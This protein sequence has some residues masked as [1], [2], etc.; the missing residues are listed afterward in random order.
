MD[1][2]KGPVVGKRLPSQSS[3]KVDWF[4]HLPFA[5]VTV[6]HK[7]GFKDHRVAVTSDRKSQSPTHPQE[8]QLTWEMLGVVFGVD[9]S[10]VEVRSHLFLPR[11][12][13]TFAIYHMRVTGNYQLKKAIWNWVILECSK[14]SPTYFI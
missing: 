5:K 6:I 8:G 9:S 10:R 2:A 14:I 12:I 4:P 11:A 3:I 7:C 1:P 13:R